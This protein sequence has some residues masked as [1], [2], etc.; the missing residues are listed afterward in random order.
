MNHINLGDYG[1][2]KVYLWKTERTSEELFQEVSNKVRNLYGQINYDDLFHHLHG[3]INHINASDNELFLRSELPSQGFSRSKEANTEHAETDH[4]DRDDHHDETFFEIFKNASY[5][6]RNGSLS[7]SYIDLGEKSMRVDRVNFFSNVFIS[8]GVHELREGGIP[9][10]DDAIPSSSP[11]DEDAGLHRMREKLVHLINTYN[12]IFFRNSCVFVQRV[13]VIPSSDK[14]DDYIMSQIMRINESFLYGNGPGGGTVGGDVGRGNGDGYTKNTAEVAPSKDIVTDVREKKKKKN[15]YEYMKEG[16]FPLLK[17][18]A[19]YLEDKQRNLTGGKPLERAVTSENVVPRIGIREKEEEDNVVVSTRKGAASHNGVSPVST[20]GDSTTSAVAVIPSGSASAVEPS[21]AE[22]GGARSSSGKSYKGKKKYSTNFLSIFQKASAKEYKSVNVHSSSEEG[23]SCDEGIFDSWIWGGGTGGNHSAHANGNVGESDEHRTTLHGEKTTLHRTNTMIHGGSSATHEPISFI[24]KNYRNFRIIVFLPSVKKHFNIQYNKFFQA[25][26]LNAFYIFALSLHSMMTKESVRKYMEELMESANC[27]SVRTAKVGSESVL[28]RR[29]RRHLEGVL[30]GVSRTFGKAQKGE[31]QGETGITGT[32]GVNGTAGLHLKKSLSNR[33]LSSKANLT[34]RKNSHD[35]NLYVNIKRYYNDVKWSILSKTS[36]MTTKGGEMEAVQIDAVADL[37]GG[38]ETDVIHSERRD[39]DPIGGEV[40]SLES[41]QGSGGGSPDR[42]SDGGDKEEEDT[43]KHHHAEDDLLSEDYNGEQSEDYDEE[44]SDQYNDDCGG[45]H[46]GFRE[47]DSQ[48]VDAIEGREEDTTFPGKGEHPQGEAP[49]KKSKQSDKGMVRNKVYEMRKKEGDVFLLLGSPLD[50]LESYLECYEMVKE[51][52]NKDDLSDGNITFCI[53]LSM[54]LYVTQNWGHFCRLNNNEKYTFRFAEVV[55]N[56]LVQTYERLLP[57]RYTNYANFFFDASSYSGSMKERSYHPYHNNA[58]FSLYSFDHTSDSPSSGVAKN[59]SSFI[60]VLNVYDRGEEDGEDYHSGDESS[61][62]DFYFFNVTIKGHNTLIYLIGFMEHKLSESLSAMRNACVVSPGGESDSTTPLLPAQELFADYLLCYLKYLLAIKKKRHIFTAMRKYS[63]VT[64]RFSHQLYVRFYVELANIYQHIGASRKFAF[65]IYLL[66]TRFFEHRRFYL[67]YVFL[68]SLLPFY[69]LPC[70]QVDFDGGTPPGVPRSTGSTGKEGRSDHPNELLNRVFPRKRCN[71][72]FPMRWLKKASEVH[73]GEPP[74]GEGNANVAGEEHQKQKQNPNEGINTVLPIGRNIAALLGG[75]HKEETNQGGVVLPSQNDQH[76]HVLFKSVLDA[77]SNYNLKRLLWFCSR[78]ISIRSFF[79][80][81]KHGEK[82][83]MYKKKRKGQNGK[84]Q[85]GVLALLSEVLSRLNLLSESIVCNLLL[86]FFLAKVLRKEV[87]RLILCNIYETLRKSERH[88]CF[89]PFVTLVMDKREKRR[90]RSYL[91]RLSQGGDVCFAGGV[92]TKGGKMYQGG[93]PCGTLSWD[94]SSS[95]SSSSELD[96]SSSDAEGRSYEGGERSHEATKNSHLLALPQKQ[97]KEDK[98]KRK[99][100]NRGK[101]NPQRRKQIHFLCGMTEGRC[102]PSPVLLNIEY[103]NEKNNCEKFYKKVSFP[104]SEGKG[105]EEHAGE[106][107][108]VFKYNPFNEVERNTKIQNICELNSVNQV[109]VT[110]KNTLSTNL[111]L[112]SIR[113]ITSGVPVETY[114]SNVVFLMSRKKNHTTKVRLSFRAKETGLLFLLGVSYCIS[115]LHFDQYLLYDTSVLRKCFM[116]GACGKFITGESF[117]SPPPGGENHPSSTNCAQKNY[118]HVQ[119][120]MGE[121]E[122]REEYCAIAGTENNGKSAHGEEESLCSKHNIGSMNRTDGAALLSYALK[123]SNTCSVFVIRNYFC[124]NSEIKLFNFSRYVDVQSMLHDGS[125][126]D[127]FCRSSSGASQGMRRDDSLWKVADEVTGEVAI[128]SGASPPTGGATPKK[129][130]LSVSS[131]SESSPE[132]G[133]QSCDPIARLARRSWSSS[134][135][136]ASSTENT[137]QSSDEEKTNHGSIN[138][139]DETY[140]NQ[141]FSI[142]ARHTELLE[143]ETKFL[144]LILE[145]KSS[146]VD[147]NYLN[148][149]VK[150]KHKNLGDFF[151][152]F[153]FNQAFQMKRNCGN[154]QK[155][156][157]IRIGKGEPITVRR[158]HCLYI[159]IRCIGSI[160]INECDVRVIYSSEKSNPYYAVQKIK[161]RLS[162]IRNVSV[163]QLFCF[164]YVSF[165]VTDVLDEMVNS[166]FYSASVINALSRVMTEEEDD[167]AEG[168][169]GN[170]IHVGNLRGRKLKC[171]EINMESYFEGGAEGYTNRRSGEVPLE[172]GPDLGG[173]PPLRKRFSPRK[174]LTICTDN[175]YMFVELF[176]RNFSGYVNYCSAKKVGRRRP[177]CVVETDDNPSKWVLWVQR[178]KRK[179]NLSFATR[180]DA[181]KYFLLY[182]D[183][184]VYLSFDRH[185]KSGLLSLYSSYLNN[186]YIY[187][188]KVGRFFLNFEKEELPSRGG[189]T[190]EHSVFSMT[191]GSIGEVKQG[192]KT[193]PK[194]ETLFCAHAEVKQTEEVSRVEDCYPPSSTIAKKKSSV[195]IPKCSK[196]LNFKHMNEIGIRKNYFESS[197]GEFFVIKIFLKNLSPLNLGEYTLLVYPS[198][199]SCIKLIGSLSS[200]GSLSQTWTTDNCMPKGGKKPKRLKKKTHLLHSLNVYSLFPGK[201]LFY[202]AV[203]FHAYHALLFHHEPVLLRYR[204]ARMDSIVLPGEALGSSD[205]Y[206]SGEN[207]YILQKEVR[208][209]ILGRRQLVT[210]SNGKQIISVA[211]TKDFIPLPQVGDLVTCKVYRVTFNVIYCNIILLNNRAIKNSFRAFINKSDIHVYDGELG[212]NFECFKQGD[213]IRAK[214]LSVGQ[215]GSYKL[216]TVGSD[217]GVILALSDKGQIMKPVAWNLMVNLS[218]MSFEKRKV[219][220]DFSVPL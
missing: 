73:P 28:D 220:R 76:S 180:E 68:N 80:L 77:S 60:N 169:D 104:P 69:G 107:K 142:D 185:K 61:E 206:V 63:C 79:C 201:V 213:I 43:E 24:C 116:G 181:V 58:H 155:A 149:Q 91:R 8:I 12:N 34:S 65:T 49:R 122:S 41:V 174:D 167:L 212:D 187:G 166:D 83:Q 211:N 183:V 136:M 13:L 44:E 175:K 202:V 45:G 70:V 191:D 204:P 66:C 141:Y 151:L 195:I 39:G 209:S 207:T 123:M 199:F 82:L 55:E 26:L 157:V 145:N 129:S 150:Y 156:D 102:A 87:Q 2:A 161:L 99:N 130:S 214:V 14:Y 42:R 162:V 6:R 132:L 114:A 88:I 165:N 178:I 163:D 200:S 54:Y 40:V 97:P 3:Y 216:S 1:K 135:D 108:D 144:C 100:S 46:E 101:N 106:E 15:P 96:S 194:R 173:A 177:T 67:T 140:D 64:E 20:K 32:D 198:N 121:N 184:H 160:L 9:T 31:E 188:N 16:N 170:T 118:E 35:N 38:E 112:N 85:H 217:L 134:S 81:N 126:L 72:N 57:S 137:N 143:G 110:L 21:T 147:I 176:I 133:N 119:V 171:T 71:V 159:P 50:S 186:V 53:A 113:L 22:G 179:K 208:S 139:V 219:S 29:R 152:K 128:Q 115:Y 168:P 193:A 47:E 105:M 56:M 25:V 10:T 7:I 197:V 120:K 33:D 94:S 148:V 17:N 218:D 131:S 164:P 182:I 11:P 90:S 109:E 51:G 146:H 172:K 36:Q 89:P 158:D 117:I 75:V 59:I 103:I 111:V 86:L 124:L 192:R 4:A 92:H 127:R 205:L 154:D 30:P 190:H 125:D 37:A 138:H 95:G 210:D 98:S 78:E 5:V 189:G 93:C 196:A 23:V 74:T 27:E 84:L 62:K 52:G 203:Y 215:H 153:F 19:Y 18:S 48:S